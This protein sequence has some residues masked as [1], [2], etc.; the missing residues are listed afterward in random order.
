MRTPSIEVRTHDRSN[1][2]TAYGAEACTGKT[3]HGTEIDAARIKDTGGW[4]YVT[5]PKAKCF[6]KAFIDCTHKSPK[7]KIWLGY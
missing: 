2:W 6:G 5:D 1:A 3:E 4:G 7:G